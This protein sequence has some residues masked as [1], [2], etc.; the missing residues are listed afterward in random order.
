MNKLDH[1]STFEKMEMS[2]GRF[3]AW[4]LKECLENLSGFVAYF[5]LDLGA[6]FENWKIGAFSS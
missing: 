4:K 1:G 3:G 6:E 5:F 2:R